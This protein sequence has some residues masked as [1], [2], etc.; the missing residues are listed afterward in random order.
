MHEPHHFVQQCFDALDLTQTCNG[1]M[2]YASISSSFSGSM[3][4]LSSMMA[5]SVTGELSSAMATALT[6]SDQCSVPVRRNHDQSV[7][8][9]MKSEPFDFMWLLERCDGESQLMLDVLRSF[10]EQGRLH[11]NAVQ[12]SAKDVD[13]QKLSFHAV[14]WINC[15]TLNHQR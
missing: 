14:I 15:Y 1:Q 3:G 13:M 4:S 12:N 5:R 8:Y 11:I 6:F 9:Q 10:C 2:D 7:A